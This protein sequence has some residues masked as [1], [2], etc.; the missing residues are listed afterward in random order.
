MREEKWENHNNDKVKHPRQF[1]TIEVD[2][3]SIS[4]PPHPDE[5]IAKPHGITPSLSLCFSFFAN[6]SIVLVRLSFL[7]ALFQ[8]DSAPLLP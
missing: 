7:V 2:F 6:P 3:H 8:F 5:R 1:P 4:N